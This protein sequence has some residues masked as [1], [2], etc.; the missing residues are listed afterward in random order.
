MAVV[1]DKLLRRPVLFAV[2]IS[3][4]VLYSGFFK[5]S[6]KNPAV[7]LFAAEEICQIE[8]KILSS[9]VKTSSDKYYFCDFMLTKVFKENYAASSAKGIIKL[10]IPK[11]DIEALYPDHLYSTSNAN[12]TKTSIF[13]S[14]LFASFTGTFNQDLCFYSKNCKEVFWKKDFAGRL[15]YFRA[16]CRLNFKR[17]MYKW[18]GAGGFLLALLCGSKD[19]L[20]KITAEAFRKAGLSHILALS[21]MH[22]SLFSSL[23]LFTGKK[24]G[25]IRISYLLQLIVISIFVWFAGL[26]PSLLR[27]FICTLLSVIAAISGISWIK[28]FDILCISFLIQCA[29]CPSHIQ[30]AGF[31]LSYGALAGI[32][33]LSSFFHRLFVRV[34]PDKVSSS[35]SASLAAQ[36]LTAPISLLLFGSFAPV[37]IIATMFISPLVTYFIYFGLFLI[38]L[39]LVFPILQFPSAFFM[40]FLYTMIKN[41]VLFFS[42]APLLEVV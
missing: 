42:R 4:F 7:F 26:S 18:G 20:E 17:L 15:S 23:A 12:K 10:Y 19:F 8:G 2:F 24:T 35:F 32:C 33:L 5:I 14:G 41:L 25:S 9:P 37:G 1:L 27:A 22:L 3:C 31:L 34:I 36:S 39:T 30:N 29:V 11:Q 40:N 6:S 21:G 28:T 16:V 38:I 13:E